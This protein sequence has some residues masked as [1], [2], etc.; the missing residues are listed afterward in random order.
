[1]RNEGE[2]AA[3][4]REQK[5]WRKKIHSSPTDLTLRSLTG[6][7]FASLP[8]REVGNGEIILRPISRKTKRR[9]C[10]HL[11]AIFSVLGTLDGAD[12]RDRYFSYAEREG[13]KKEKMRNEGRAAAG[14][15]NA[16]NKYEPHS[17]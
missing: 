2:R 17:S 14:R 7:L 6:E 13:R 9:T 15:Q 12:E 1:M 11:E 3:E 16:I 4:P 8:P 5:S 10:F